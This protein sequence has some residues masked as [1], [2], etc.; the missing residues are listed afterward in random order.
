[1]RGAPYI[2]GLALA[3]TA[4]PAAWSQDNP[5]SL[6]ARI[7]ASAEAAE[8]LQGPLD[9]G[10]TLAGPDGQAIYAF[11]IVDKPGGLDPL[12]GVWRDLRRPTMPGD[13]GLIDTL[14]RG[15][16][17]LTISFVLR[18]GAPTTVIQLRSGA[19]GGWSGEL[20][21]GGAVTKVTLRRS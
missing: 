8:S 12:E 15:A 9:G 10:W 18:P 19:D 13:I 3:A 7:R 21:E 17:A 14:Q 1:M 4:A 11:Q 2:L 20:R 5:E 6:D 16:G